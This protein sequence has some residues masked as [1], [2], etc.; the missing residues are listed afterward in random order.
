L[1]RTR[2]EEDVN[3][4]SHLFASILSLVTFFIIEINLDLR[5]KQSASIFTMCA[6]SSWT[7]ASSFL[8]HYSEKKIIKTRN[9]ILDK[10]GIYLMI[11]ASGIAMCLT[12]NSSYFI[13][14]YSAVMISLSCFLILKMCL[15]DKE[16]ETFSVS[17]Y[18]LLSLICILPITGIFVE[19]NHSGSSAFLLLTLGTISY[20][21][22]VVFYIFDK[23]KWFHSVWHVMVM[24]GFYFNLGSTLCA[25]NVI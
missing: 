12:L 13:L 5:A 4:A 6:I 10:A 9:R 23:I 14:I 25:L 8:Y 7:F 17:S 15:E 3:A 2:K 20:V 11:M 1:F 19:T 18:I 16:N 24:A 22:G 21:I